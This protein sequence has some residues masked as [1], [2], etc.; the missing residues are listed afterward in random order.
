MGSRRVKG[1][2]RERVSMGEEV[3]RQKKR[4]GGGVSMR[5]VR[6]KRGRD[7][8]ARRLMAA[9]VVFERKGQY[10][11]RRVAVFQQVEARVDRLE[12]RI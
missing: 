6:E 10:L 11:Y 12:K 7:S 1:R 9:V 4:Q 3:T 5:E 8:R 2:V